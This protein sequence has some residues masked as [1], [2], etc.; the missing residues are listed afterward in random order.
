M[1]NLAA[2]VREISTWRIGRGIDHDQSQRRAMTPEEKRALHDAL[3][4]TM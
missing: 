3:E 4:K 1:H 2:A